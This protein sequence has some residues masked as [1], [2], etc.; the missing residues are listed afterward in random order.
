M[1]TTSACFL[2]VFNTKLV[3]STPGQ[4]TT[5]DPSLPLPSPELL[6]LH[7]ALCKIFHLSG[8]AA[9]MPNLSKDNY[10]CSPELRRDSDIESE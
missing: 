9:Y 1:Y 8:R 7:L 4:L 3:S 10:Y 5:P 6:S 2:H